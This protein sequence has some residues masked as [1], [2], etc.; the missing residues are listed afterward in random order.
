MTQPTS[1]S[2]PA[3]PTT[4][5]N[6]RTAPHDV[7]IGRA[8]RG[9]EGYF[10]NPFTVAQHGAKAIELFRDRYFLPRLEHDATFR[11]RVLALRGQQLG[12]FCKPRPGHGDV[13]AA[14]ID[15]PTGLPRHGVNRYRCRNMASRAAWAWAR[16][17]DQPAL[18]DPERR[19]PRSRGFLQRLQGLPVVGETGFE[20][21]TPWSRSAPGG[22]GR[23][24]TGSHGFAS[25]R[26]H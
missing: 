11:A 23:R 20:P 9:E 15:G 2:T 26:D 17:L 7:Y 13:M 18:P 21:A 25:Y 3:N 10:G 19:S 6:L 5:V 1:S 16:L 8:G 14:W 24:G 22:C 12:C 4:V